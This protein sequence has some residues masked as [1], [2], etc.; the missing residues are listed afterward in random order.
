MADVAGQEHIVA[1]LSHALKNGKLSHAYLFTGPRGVGKTSVARILAYEAN[2][3]TYTDDQAQL[4][5]IEIDAASNRR[6]DEIR[7]L[8]DK[9]RMLPAHAKYKVY[10]ID[11]VHMLTKEAFN[12][13]LKT[14]EEPPEH[15][16]FILATTEAHKLPQT[17][18]SRT[19][20]FTFKPIDIET[21]A[22]QLRKIA[23]QEK[24]SID[25]E[26]L[27]LIARH[28]DGSFRDSIS[29]LD[30]ISN[31][32][33][34]IDAAAVRKVL[35]IA[36]QE[37]TD[38]LLAA[39]SNHDAKLCMQLLAKLRDQGF[40]AGQVSK[41]LLASLRES[42]IN[43]TGPLSGEQTIGLL[44][45]L[46]EV[47]ASGNPDQMLELVLLGIVFSEGKAKESNP[48]ATEEQI[49]PGNLSIP[50]KPKPKPKLTKPQNQAAG[51]DFSIDEWPKVLDAI[52]QQHSTLYSVL[53]MAEPAFDKAGQSLTLTFGFPFHQKRLSEAKSQ[54]MLANTVQE[55]YG[56]QISI[57]PLIGTKPKQD[58]KKPSAS[59]TKSAAT[60]SHI[61]S[62]N[63]V[64]GNAE[65]LDS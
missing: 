49:V 33:K 63:N 12:A 4:D 11:E 17:I 51:G 15:V 45:Q 10:I 38:E 34:K 1:T 60:P 65:V 5:I 29:L 30:Q 3:L 42:L 46:V 14:L 56:Q 58:P 53:R 7:D 24:L 13:L 36:S 40:A 22:G 47:P 21:L 18:I 52:K 9:V 61:N 59:T 32:S 2:G 48:R 20:R 35:G 43:N 55:L 8:R 19:Q 6:I 50:D 23:A 41:Q 37:L 39:V 16:I 57:R 28:G 62:V 26:A 31:T 27:G 64:F 54:Q 25:D 44:K